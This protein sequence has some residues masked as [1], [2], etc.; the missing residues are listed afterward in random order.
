MEITGKFVGDMNS[1]FVEFEVDTLPT[2]EER[3]NIDEN[4]SCYEAIWMGKSKAFESGVSLM[5]GMDDCENDDL[6][7][8][9]GAMSED[10]VMKIKELKG[11]N[12]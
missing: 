12:F 5:I 10:D 11:D 6:D 4:K 7:L 9:V 1:S 8:L 3:D 2:S